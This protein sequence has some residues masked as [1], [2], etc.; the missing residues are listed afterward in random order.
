MDRVEE[1]VQYC[2]KNGLHVILNVHHDG[3]DDATYSKAWLTPEPADEAA[4]A[5]MKIRYRR[6]WEQIA[7]RF[8]DYSNL[9]MFASMNEFHHGYNAPSKAYSTLQN[10]LHQIFVD[11]VRGTGSNNALRYLVIP[12]YN[13]NIGYTI[14]SL[15]LPEDTVDDQLMVEVHY[16]DPYT[17]ATDGNETDQWGSDYGGA[18][19]ADSW[20]Q[21]RYLIEELK[22]MKTAFIDKNIPV[23][24]GEFGAPAKKNSANEKYRT[25]YLQYVV[26]YAAEYGMVPVYWD[27]GTSYKLF[28]RNTCEVVYPDIVNGMMDALQP[29]YT[30]PLPK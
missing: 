3:N 2:T 21:E 6:L 30:V 8:K 28:S 14:S 11:T 22:K 20:G 24:L 16:Y 23:I 29:G 26:K 25:Y 9:V 13:T 10:E 19:A 7:T 1:V 17:Y 18:T 15:K 4:A 5:E 27:N 12:G